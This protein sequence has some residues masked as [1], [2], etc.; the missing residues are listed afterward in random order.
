MSHF[1]AYLSRMKFIERWGL[2]RCTYPENIQEHSLR[3]AMIA[4]AL[5]IIRNRLFDGSLNPDRAAVLAMYHDASEVVT[6]DM[7]APIKYFN[8]AI[9]DAYKDIEAHAQ[10]RM[11]AMIPAEIREEYRQ[12]F[13]L[14]HDD[15]H[16]M[17]VKAA[18][19][20]CAYIKC[21]EERGAGNKEFAQ[22]ELSLKEMIDRMDLPE[23]D[24]F[25]RTF[26][27]SIGLTLDELGEPPG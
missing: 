2:M 13:D 25:M 16:I 19:K 14:S 10:D 22:A 8:P 6:G 7:P 11:I 27:P 12:V 1:F 17:L 15:E 24:Y 4:H 20:I 18:D 9:R 3:V 5:A 21:V 23:V 26:M